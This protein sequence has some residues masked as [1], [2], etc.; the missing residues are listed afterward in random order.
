M[1]AKYVTVLV[2]NGITEKMDV[3]CFL[4][5]AAVL[6]Q[7]YGTDNITVA[8][9]LP[10]EAAVKIDAAEEYSRL[11]ML[12][13]NEQKSGLPYVERAFGT[14]DPV[15]FTNAVEALLPAA[16]KAAK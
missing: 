13:G 7:V 15:G 8:D 4:H 14:F 3:T 2:H 5:E 10:N 16:A 11:A 1:K 6:K 9:D 12:Y